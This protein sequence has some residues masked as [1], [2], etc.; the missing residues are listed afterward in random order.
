[1][2]QQKARRISPRLVNRGGEGILAED[3]ESSYV[4]SRSREW[5][6]FKCMNEQE[7]VIRGYA[8]PQG[9]R[10]GFGA[11]L[12]GYHERKKLRYAGKVGTGY[13]TSALK[14]MHQPLTS[15]ESDRM[16]FDDA[17]P[18][19]NTFTGL[20]RG[21]WHRLGFRSGPE[22]ESCD[23]RAS[24]VCVTTKAPRKLSG[25]DKDGS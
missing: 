17:S 23:S 10:V 11:L 5:L 20:S 21:W 7:F 6:K 18:S 24:L 8:D 12:V 9:Q 3:G 19:D 25:R 16:F 22:T 14:R 15:I 2:L 13:D 1:M 4:S